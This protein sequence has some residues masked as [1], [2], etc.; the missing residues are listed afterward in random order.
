MSKIMKFFFA[1]NCFFLSVSL[2]A[3]VYNIPEKPIYVIV[4][5][6]NNIKWWSWNLNSILKQ[7]YGNVHIVITDDNSTD[8]T[9]GEIERFI[10][11]HA[12]Q[13]RVIIF[14]NDERHGAL[15]NLFTMIHGC[16][17]E[18]IIV[19]VDGDD[20]LPDNPT[21]LKK[22][23]EVYSNPTKE[24]WLTYG[25]FELY[26]EKK[27][28]WCK[29]FP[30]NII[31]ANAFR[32]FQDIPSHLRTFYA[33]LFKAIKVEDLLYEGKFFEMSW[34]CAMM[35]P[36]IEMAGERHQFINEI[37]YLYNTQNLISDHRKDQKL[38]TSLAQY[39]RS[40]QRYTRLNKKI[41]K[42]KKFFKERL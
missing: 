40:K 4:P 13:D 10:K 37:M 26:P 7:N 15:Y 22:L 28:G 11:E 2:K 41:N 16:P 31:K 25:Q 23:N 17:D 3:T 21:L 33:W 5:T 36:M 30:E 14:L 24:V 34:D 9:G 39:I 27:R 19:T 1:L 20:A 38:Q 12:L 18:A 6:Y 35:F 8:G 42:S 32:T 29:S